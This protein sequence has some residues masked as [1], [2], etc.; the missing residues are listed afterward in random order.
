[1]KKRKLGRKLLSFLLALAMVMGLMPGMNFTAYADT[2][3]HLET[4]AGE[5]SIQPLSATASKN[6]ISKY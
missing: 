6:T 5:T 4:N 1:M 2:V 3:N